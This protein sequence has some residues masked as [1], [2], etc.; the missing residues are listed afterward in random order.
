MLYSQSRSSPTPLTATAPTTRA[1]L[2]PHT[3]PSSHIQPIIEPSPHIQ[4]EPVSAT[5]SNPYTVPIPNPTSVTAPE[6]SPNPEISP[7]PETASTT[8]P[9]HSSSHPMVTRSKNH[10]TKP[11]PTPDGMIRYPLPKALLAV[12]HTTIFEPEPTCFTTA[13]K[14]HAGIKP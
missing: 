11:K 13:A 1:S 7:P 4:P 9:S 5:Y 3:E 8:H 6:P 12:A 10:I 14:S 2:S